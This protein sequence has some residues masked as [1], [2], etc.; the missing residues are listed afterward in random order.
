[1]SKLMFTIEYVQSNPQ[2]FLGAGI[3][4]LGLTLGY[5]FGK[6]VKRSLLAF[7]IDDIMNS[8]EFERGLNQFNLTTV[9]LFSH[10]S[11]WFVYILAL[12][13]AANVAGYFNQTLF[14]DTAITFLPQVFTSIL[15]LLIGVVLADKVALLIQDRLEQFKLPRLVVLP[16]VAKYTIMYVALLVALGQIGV[17]TTA[18]VV[19]LVVYVFGLILFGAIASRRLLAAGSSGIYILLLEPYGIGD[20]VQIGDEKGVVQEVEVLF[21]YLESED[22]T[23]HIIPNN[24]IFEYGIQRQQN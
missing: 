23:E 2:L 4:I 12:F 1:M 9:S 7:G 13:L 5:L 15:A 8:S 17:E 21:T 3:A 20:V 16:N 22:G 19:L 14:W 11:S 10:L 6:F 24:K 18:L